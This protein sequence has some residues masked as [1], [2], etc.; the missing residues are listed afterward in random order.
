MSLRLFV[1]GL[2]NQRPMSG[3]DIKRSLRSLSWLIGSPSPGSLYPALRGLLRDDLVTVQVV[4]RP[5]KPPRKEYH[6]T[7]VGERVLQEWMSRPAA[8]GTVKTFAMRLI[9][10]TNLAPAALQVHLETRRAEVARCHDA[11]ELSISALGEHA[12][13][14][15][16]LAL[17]YGLTVARSELAWLDGILQRLN[18]QE[19]ASDLTEAAEG[20]PPAADSGVRPNTEPSAKQA[21]S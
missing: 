5:D 21:A 9:L 4:V 3:Y 17:D 20:W 14:R 13:F 15:Q 2:L 6:V 12:D 16:Q 10:A 1:L 18:R 8:P 11:L 19:A 7:K